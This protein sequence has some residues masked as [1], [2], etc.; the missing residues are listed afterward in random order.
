VVLHFRQ[1]CSASFDYCCICYRSFFSLPI[2]GLG[3]H[4]LMP[5]T[6]GTTPSDAAKGA[7]RLFLNRAATPPR[8]ACPSNV[9]RSGEGVNELARASPLP[10]GE[11][12][13]AKREP[14]RAKHQERPGEGKIRHVSSVPSPERAKKRRALPSPRGRGLPRPQNDSALLGQALRGG[15]SATSMNYCEASSMERTGW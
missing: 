15:M 6:L 3:N 14:D 13:R 2:V 11:D 5:G 7:S 4:K 12:G 9:C 8:R 1:N 10:L